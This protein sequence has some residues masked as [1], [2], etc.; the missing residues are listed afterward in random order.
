M[1]ENPDNS[2]RDKVEM[3]QQS[4][5]PTPWLCQTSKNREARDVSC[6][7]GNQGKMAGNSKVY[8]EFSYLWNL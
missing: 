6:I 5:R 8:M 2:L 3:W 1:I 7:M 4:V